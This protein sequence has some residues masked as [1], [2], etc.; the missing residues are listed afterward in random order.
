MTAH[1]IGVDVGT[2]SARAGVFE[3]AGRLLGA[4]RNPI[5]IWY[6]P[7]EIVEQSSDDIW[8]ACV[9]AVRTA[10]AQAGVAPEAIAGIGFGATCSLVVLDASG[11][12]L[13][14]SPSGDPARNVIVW[15]DHRATDQARRINATEHPVLDYVGGIISPEMETPKLLWLKE[16]LPRSFAGAGHFFDLA[17]FLTFRATGDEARSVCTLACKWTYLA[18]EHRWSPDFFAEIGLPELNADGFRRIG[19]KILAPG[20]PIGRGLSTA[21]AA[22]LGL[23]PGTPVGAALIDAHAGGVG[24]LGAGPTERLGYILGTSACIMASTAEPTFVPGVWGP[25]YGAMFQNLWLNEGGQS[26][27]GAAIDRLVETHPA[28]AEAAAKAEGAGIPVHDHLERRIASRDPDLSRAAELA[29]DLHV[30]PEFLGNRSPFA[31]PQARAAILGLGFD[32][33]LEGLERLFVAGLCGVAYGFADVID[34]FARQGIAPKLVVASGG[35]SKSPLVRQIVADATGLPVALPETPEPVLLGAAMLGAVA[36]GAHAGLD[37]A[38]AAMS[39]IGPLTA[40]TPARATAF[41]AAKREIYRSLREL[42]FASR[43][44]MGRLPG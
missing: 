35:A 1:F 13:T 39:R 4:G 36:A 20:T 31:D 7:G 26:A 15:M 3:S 37:A 44:I 8:A 38:A 19:R 23:V 43:G 12:P 33:D 21:A 9:A 30:V 22:E 5:R 34:A 42:D 40:P 41:H 28:H 14:V 25:Y 2:G 27:A 32:A 6:E 29:R 17:D 24:T 18:H 11:G 16:H 10:V